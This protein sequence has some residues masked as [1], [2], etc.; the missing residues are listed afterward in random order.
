MIGAEAASHYGSGS[1]QLMWL[2]LCYTNLIYSLLTVYGT[3]EVAS[4]SFSLPRNSA[5]FNFWENFVA[6]IKK[7]PCKE[8]YFFTFNFFVLGKFHSDLM[9]P[10]PQ[11]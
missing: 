11:F 8:E 10:T 6:L 5:K 3:G 9:K 7:H 4:G 2:R 1:T